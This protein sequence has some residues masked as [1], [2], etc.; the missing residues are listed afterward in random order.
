MPASSIPSQL[1]PSPMR[2]FL[3][4]IERLFYL[5]ISRPHDADPG[6]HRWVVVFCNSLG[7]LPT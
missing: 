5:P 4:G 7:P 3:A 2:V 1:P 6:E